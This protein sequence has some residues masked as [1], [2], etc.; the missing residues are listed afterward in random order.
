MYMKWATIYAAEIAD[1]AL[2]LAGFVSS[3]ATARLIGSKLEI[4]WE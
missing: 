3:T 2:A 1:L 4:N